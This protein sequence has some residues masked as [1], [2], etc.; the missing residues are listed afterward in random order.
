M[1]FHTDLD[2]SGVITDEDEEEP[3]YA[4]SGIEVT[5]EMLDTADEKR[6]AAMSAMSEGTIRP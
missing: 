4:D 3:E 1:C 5:D 2:Q 6:G